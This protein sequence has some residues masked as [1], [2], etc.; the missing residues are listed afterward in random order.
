MTHVIDRKAFSDTVAL[1]NI[2]HHCQNRAM[3]MFASP[4]L[5]GMMAFLLVGSPLEAHADA[6]PPKS[7]LVRI[8]GESDRLTPQQRAQMLLES[9]IMY[10]CVLWDTYQRVDIHARLWAELAAAAAIIAEAEE[11]DRASLFD[12]YKEAISA[13]VADTPS[14]SW[15]ADLRAQLAVPF[16][17]FD[18]RG[19]QEIIEITHVV[20]VLGSREEYE[21]Y[22]RNESRL[23]REHSAALEARV[24]DDCP[25]SSRR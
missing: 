13:L 2:T 5:M 8:D 12:R 19:V 7:P 20:L 15:F 21:A 24:P 25:S 9:E 4:I 16:D 3:K 22:S 11:V 17:R 6:P 23:A 10:R 1:M 14:Q 18:W